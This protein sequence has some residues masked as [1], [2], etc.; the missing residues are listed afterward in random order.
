MAEDDV[1]ISKNRIQAMCLL[2][3][4]PFCGAFLYYGLRA[5][6]PE[7]AKYANRMS[8]LSWAVWILL[9]AIGT[10]THVLR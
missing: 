8:W 9:T 7:A 10:Q 4:T 3:L 5:K 2:L 6:H 1:P